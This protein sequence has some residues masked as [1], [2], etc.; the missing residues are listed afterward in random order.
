MSG[1]VRLCA[2]VCAHT[3]LSSAPRRWLRTL[4]ANPRGLCRSH[5]LT[6]RAAHGRGAKCRGG[7][8][9]FPITGV[10]DPFP[11]GDAGGGQ[12][13]CGRAG[14]GT[15]PA[16]TNLILQ[17]SFSPNSYN[18]STAPRTARPPGTGLCTPAEGSGP[19]TTGDT[20]ATGARQ[21]WLLR[22]RWPREDGAQRLFPRRVRLGRGRAAQAVSPKGGIAVGTGRCHNTGAQKLSPGFVPR[23][24]A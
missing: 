19:G 8:H 24:A 3:G 10:L 4:A 23:R 2:H 7:K 20:G 18:R 6:G 22:D 16:A 14:V 1:G 13:D 15:R 12:G 11:C 21:G 5:R 9:A 17:D